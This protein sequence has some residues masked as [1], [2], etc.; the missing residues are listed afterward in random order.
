[1]L[2]LIVSREFTALLKSKAMRVSTAIVVALMLIGGGVAGFLLGG[3][4]VDVSIPPATGH[5]AQTNPLGFI[6]GMVAVMFVAIPI[7]MGMGALNSGV[8]E[9][10]T[11][12]V[13]EIILTTVKPRTLL[14]AKLL[15]IGSAVL[16]FIACYLAGI[17][18]G[19]GLAGVLPSMENLAAAHLN[20]WTFAPAVL[21][22]LAVGYFTFGGL[23][24]ALAS[25]VSRQEDLG[26][27]QTPVIFGAMIPMYVALYLVPYAPNTTVTHILSCCP[28]LS[29]FMMPM[30]MALGAVGVWEQLLAFAV[31]I[32]TICLLSLLAGKVYERS[33]LHTGERLKLRQALRGR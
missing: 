24:G 16:V 19:A 27:V 9:E 13:V 20:P 1:M 29:P 12:R 33:I 23:S 26:A 21:V 17:V 8:V 18:A 6:V 4:G 11:S 7:F 14:L 3:K 2:G 32:A 28:F 31:Q 22:W 5:T 15:G 25:T 30:R 10:K